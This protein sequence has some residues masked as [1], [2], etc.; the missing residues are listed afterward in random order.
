[1]SRRCEACG[2]KAMS[3]HSL[4]RRGLA[5]AKGGVGIKTTA[6]NKRKFYPNL[7]SK[8]VVINGK[9]KKIKV[10]TECIRK[11]KLTFT[12]GKS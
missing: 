7:Q 10:C 1:M 11:G 9:I 4:S 12:A 5:K 6:T 8:K 3:G 2:K